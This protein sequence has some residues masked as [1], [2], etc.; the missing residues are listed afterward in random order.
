[1]S[2]LKDKALRVNLITM[3]IL[4]ITTIYDFIFR[5]GEKL[6][7][8]GLM[9]ITLWIM[10]FV[11]KK[12]FLRK[13]RISFYLIYS[14]IIGAM[15]LGNV[16]DFYTIIPMYDKIL[17]LLSGLIIEMIG[18]ILFLH[19]SNGSED[20]SFKRYMPMLF[21]IIFSIAAAAVWEIWE[22][23]TDQLFGFASQNN[24]LNDTMWDI[25]CGTL[26]GIV[27]NIPIYLYHIKSK[28][29]KFIENINKQINEGK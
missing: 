5:G 21:S 9:A 13:A 7:R 27:A 28:K 4:L 6:F 22:F 25:I 11:Y 10:Y 19:V 14:F 20:N 17:H 18:Y 2:L 16:F 12:T 3:V 24:S 1:M 26:M 29:I 8:I 23:S 15:Y